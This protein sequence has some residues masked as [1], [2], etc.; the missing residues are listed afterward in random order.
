MDDACT[1]LEVGD[2]AG[3]AIEPENQILSLTFIRSQHESKLD[4]I[5]PLHVGE[6]A[7]N[8]GGR[9]IRSQFPEEKISFVL[10]PILAAFPRCAGGLLQF[11]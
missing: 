9:T 7:A 6:N 11:M 1:T 8:L 3:P 2:G 4:P 10:P 5:D